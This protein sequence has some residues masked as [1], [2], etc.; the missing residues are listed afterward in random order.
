MTSE[1]DQLMRMARR[2][3]LKTSG[4]GLGATALGSL[5]PQNVG[6]RS[7]FAPKAKKV[8]FLFMAG[9][10]SQIDLFDYKPELEKQF[11]EP[12]PPSI[13]QGQRVTAMTRGKKQLIAPS[14]FKFK[15]S[16][17]T[18]LWMSELL[19]HLSSVSD[20]ICQIKSLQTKSINHDPGKTFICT[21]SEQPGKASMGA[22]L[23]YGLGAINQNL[24]EFVVLTSAFWT[25]GKRNVQGLYSR[26]WDSGPL[27]SKHQGVAFQSSGDPVLFL[28]N[29]P[30]IDRNVRRQMLDATGSLN[31]HHF[32]E[33]GDNEINTTIA[34]QEM[35][36]RM[37]ASV[38]ELTDLSQE[39]EHILDLYGPEVGKNGSFARNC[40]L[41]RRMVERGTRFVQIFHRGW[42]HHSILPQQLP[43][44]AYDVDQPAAA[45]IRDLK[46]RGLLEDTIVVM[47]GEFGRTPFC[48]GKL[49]RDDYGRDHHPRCFTGWVA[50]GG[51]KGGI[52]YGETDDFSYN[53]VKDPVPIRDFHATMLHQLGIDH[54]RLVYPFQGLDQKLTGV[55][56]AKVVKDIIV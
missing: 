7:H 49:K 48:Q 27:P 14:M 41:A 3:F 10:P 20:E 18:G 50:G 6:A 44:Q 22:W 42:D 17:K 12:L 45:L 53:V 33:I 51:F 43:G 52:S 21:G 40:L 23:S 25:G 28:S 55:E 26:L 4:M 9:G 36:F 37:Q 54:E 8:I 11:A 38:P 56:P 13:S 29:P 31:Q 5:L 32:S 24:P 15:R 30:G 34:Q 46:Q 19:P 16:E 1:Q 35:A 2:Q 47:A 39:P